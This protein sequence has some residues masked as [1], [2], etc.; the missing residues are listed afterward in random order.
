MGVQRVALKDHR[1]AAVSWSNLVGP[2]PRD[3]QFTASNGLKTGDASEQRGLATTGR[4][5]EHNVL[6]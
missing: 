2:F 5:N 1:H 3:A 4:S 6:A